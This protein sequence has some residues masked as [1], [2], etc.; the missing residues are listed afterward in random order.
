MT[1]VFN[2]FEIAAIVLSVVIVEMISSDGETNWFEGV[3]LIAVYL[4]LSLAFFFVTPDAE[5]TPRVP[6]REPATKAS[7]AN[8]GDLR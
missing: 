1:L 8:P 7:S 4:L 2:G 5:P 6:A 3:L